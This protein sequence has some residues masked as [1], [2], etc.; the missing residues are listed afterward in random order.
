[1]SIEFP[2]SY[3]QRRLWFLAEIVPDSPAYNVAWAWL[4]SGPLDVAGLR[5]AV[6]GVMRRHQPLRT[7]FVADEGHCVQRVLDPA[8]VTDP[9]EVEHPAADR[10][11]DRAAELAATPFDLRLGG[12]L[13]VS[14][15]VLGPDEHLVVFV[16][17]HIV[18]D[19]WSSRVFER[20]LAE[21]YRAET[22][23]TAPVLPA[24]ATSYGEC[25]VLQAHQEQ[26]RFDADVSYWR[27][28]L[29]GAA[30][31][32]LREDFPRPATPTL[33][34]SRLTFSQPV[35]VFQEMTAL[36]R[37][38][39]TSPYSGFLAA[40]AILLFR[41]SGTKDVLIGSS[42]LGR[43]RPD[44]AELV[45]LF[46]NS[47]VMRVRVAPDDTFVDVVDRARDVA[48]DAQEHDSVPFDL[49]VQRLR[50]PRDLSR[51]PFFQVNLNYL[52]ESV[53]ESVGMP[54]LVVDPVEL[55][56]GT[57]H[58]DLSFSIV[59]RPDALE[60]AIDFSTDLY[61]PQ[62]VRQYAESLTALI[63]DAVRA[64]DTR[65]AELALMSGSRQR[66]VLAF[67]RSHW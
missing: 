66:E 49:L 54:G 2:L 57:S 44:S 36:T 14:V 8:D 56:V 33:R 53:T 12:L 10:A 67:G 27:E 9:V 6:A 47:L 39:R 65:V 16:V 4:L 15:L 63:A 32:R 61:R 29:A 58:F 3:A 17:H 23:G 46:V 37:T 42:T 30:Q 55:P 41:F 22:T 40:L 24:L 45:G 5:R 1:V 28:Q 60:C 25:V 48:L 62:T 64:P 18:F 38:R 19:G 52:D 50:P 26:S 59:K 34:G 13:R 7:R 43:H 11:M 31:L 21:Y 35:T 51:N 20:D